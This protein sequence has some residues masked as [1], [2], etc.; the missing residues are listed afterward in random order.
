MIA[1]K[2]PHPKVRLQR[3]RWMN[4]LIGLSF[5]GATPEG[6][7]TT[8]LSLRH[9]AALGKLQ[10]S[11]TRRCGYNLYTMSEELKSEPLLQ[12]SH[13]RRCGYNQKR[14]C[15]V[16]VSLSASKEPHPKVRLQHFVPWLVIKQ[17][18]ASKEPHPKVRLQ[19]ATSIF[20]RRRN[21]LQR[22]HTRRCGYNLRVLSRLPDFHG[23]CFKGATPEGAVTTSRMSR[24]VT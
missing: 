22:S 15:S 11:H 21:W 19:Q 14:R 18:I 5:K 3:V 23:S 16:L 7:V 12:R 24:G 17:D 4:C 2:E 6:A 20:K 9:I 13:T 1:S 8:K 10:R